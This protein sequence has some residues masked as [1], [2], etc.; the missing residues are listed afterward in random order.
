M[1]KITLGWLHTGDLFMYEN[2]VYRAGR[3]IEGTNSYVACVD[4]ITHKTT[5]LHIDTDVE[6]LQGG[7]K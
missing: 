5:R 7:A 4:V 6:T 3:L 1:N 2:K